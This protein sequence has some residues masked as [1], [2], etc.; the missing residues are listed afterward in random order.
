MPFQNDLNGRCFFMV[1]V[2]LGNP[3]RSLCVYCQLIGGGFYDLFSLLNMGS[4]GFNTTDIVLMSQVWPISQAVKLREGG[5]E[6]E[7]ERGREGER[8]RGRERE[9]E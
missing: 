4:D 3:L 2:F 9:R 7:R 8:E 1:I 5:R 6:G